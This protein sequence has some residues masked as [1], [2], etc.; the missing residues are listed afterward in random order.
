MEERVAI[1][2]IIISDP[3]SVSAVNEILHNFSDY[4]IGR[5]GLPYR[6]KKINIISVVLDAPQDA[7]SSL[8]GKI[9]KLKGVTTQTL[10]AKEA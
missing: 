7:V 2:A 10:Y 9:G 1:V 5:L 8:S 4:I 6:S 3:E